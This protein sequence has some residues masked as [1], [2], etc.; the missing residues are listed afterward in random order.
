MNN[1]CYVILNGPL[2][3]NEMGVSL[4][5]DKSEFWYNILKYIDALTCQIHMIFNR[6]NKLNIGQSPICMI[7]LMDVVIIVN[8]EYLSSDLRYQVTT[9]D[10]AH[11][12]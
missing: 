2:S 5:K 6:M 1:L 10:V 11:F 4:N 7:V 9:V 12:L 8:H 3:I